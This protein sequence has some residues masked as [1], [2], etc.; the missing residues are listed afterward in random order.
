MKVPVTHGERT[1]WGGELATWTVV[2]FSA[3]VAA[4]FLLGE[5]VGTSGGR[6]VFRLIRALRGS[7]TPA[8]RR[9]ALLGKVREAL[10]ADLSLAGLTLDV[11]F[12]S[13]GR[14]ELQGWVVSR[15]QRSHAYRLALETAGVPVLNRI[16]VRGEDDRQPFPTAPDESPRSA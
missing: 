6:R 9:S 12:G 16:L 2:G 4:G 10:R 14:I 15:R 11:G 13:R 3:G 5:M 1:G 7:G 8:E